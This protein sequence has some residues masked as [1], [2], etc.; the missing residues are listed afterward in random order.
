MA[1]EAVTILAKD[2][3]DE[4][5]SQTGFDCYEFLLGVLIRTEE[6]V[7]EIHANN[8]V[9]RNPND[10]FLTHLNLLDTTVKWLGQL[11]RIIDGQDIHL[12]EDLQ[13]IFLKL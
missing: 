3:A 13:S 4:D 10:H 5:P 1:A 8:N 12:L 9:R 11:M 6:I 7:G 2:E